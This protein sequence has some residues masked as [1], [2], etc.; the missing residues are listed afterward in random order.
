MNDPRDKKL[1]DCVLRN[2][3]TCREYLAELDKVAKTN[4]PVDSDDDL[5]ANLSRVSRLSQ[6]S[7]VDFF[8]TN[9]SDK[10]EGSYHPSVLLPDSDSDS[11]NSSVSAKELSTNSC[12]VGRTPDAVNTT[13][14][15]DSTVSPRPT[16]NNTLEH[17][18]LKC[19]VPEFYHS[20][21]NSN[22][23]D[24]VKEEK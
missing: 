15:V 4:S 18:R 8:G 14:P 17:G 22:D 21:Y 12:V 23:S 16:I 24:D 19:H 10:I 1:Y 9:D 5:S 7:L 13:V 3:Q 6:Q 2:K 20:I 11:D